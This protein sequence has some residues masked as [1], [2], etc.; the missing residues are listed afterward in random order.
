MMSWAIPEYRLPRQQL[1]A[2]IENIR[3]AGVEIVCNKALGRDFALEDLFTKQ[4]YKSVVLAIGAHRTRKLSIP[5]EDK[6]GVVD[7]I[8][9]LYRIAADASMRALNLK[10][11]GNLPVVRGKR[12]A[13]IGG[14]DV[15]ID[16]ARTA[17]RLGAREV[18]V[19]YRRAGDDMPAAHLPEEIAA[20]RDEG[21]RF[22]TLANPIEVLGGRE[23][24]RYSPAAAAPGG[25]R[26]FRPA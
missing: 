4:G 21:I 18:H 15:A 14:G 6:E 10:P 11:P 23:R 3:R 17:L 13:V 8:E 16:V 7:G 19:V 12:V 20:A 24:H 25:L 1:F 9:F 2:E 26:R 5:G 22:H